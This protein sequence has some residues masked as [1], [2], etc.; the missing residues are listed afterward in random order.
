[1]DDHGP[2]F[3]W[4]RSLPPKDGLDVASGREW[5]CKFLLDLESGLH[6]TADREHSLSLTTQAG[7]RGPTTVFYIN[8]T[9]ATID[10]G[11]V[12]LQHVPPYIPEE[13]RQALF[14]RVRAIP[15][16]NSRASSLKGYQ[17]F[18]FPASPRVPEPPGT[19]SRPL[20]EKYSIAWMQGPDRSLLVAAARCAGRRP[21]EPSRSE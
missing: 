17:P 9:H 19:C 21:S 16:Y 7:G 13:A 20:P 8:G 15:G 3:A 4:S 6:F 14:D 2:V 18:P 5:I 10:L 12:N 1:M 11:F